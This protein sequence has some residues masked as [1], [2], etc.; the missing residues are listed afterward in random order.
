MT[1]R[2]SYAETRGERGWTVVV[3][4]PGSSA[5]VLFKRAGRYPYRVDGRYRGTVLVTTGVISQE[6][7]RG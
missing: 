4:R 2:P 7:R 6:P 1:A 3:L 5:W